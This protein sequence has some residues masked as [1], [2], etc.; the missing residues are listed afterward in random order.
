M[1]TA[2]VH[3]VQWRQDIDN[4]KNRYGELGFISSNFHEFHCGRFDQEEGQEGLLENTKICKCGQTLIEHR[5]DK[6]GDQ[7]RRNSVYFGRRWRSRLSS[8]RYV[9]VATSNDPGKILEYFS[10]YWKIK[11][12]GLVISVVGD[13]IPIRLGRNFQSKLVQFS[14]DA[15]AMI[16]T[17]GLDEGITKSV[18]KVF[19]KTNQSYK[20]RKIPL[21][22]LTPW[23]LIK[24]K[25]NLVADPRTFTSS[26]RT[27][28]KSCPD[29]ET[30]GNTRLCHGLGYHM[31]VDF[32]HDQPKYY[33]DT[34]V[35]EYSEI[36][37]QYRHR[38]E[39]KLME[40]N[41]DEHSEE[42]TQLSSPVVIVLAGGDESMLTYIDLAL[43][44]KLPVL[45]I[46]G[47]DGL[48]GF[49]AN[50]NSPN[51]EFD[52][53]KEAF[54]QYIAVKRS[55]TKSERDRI[56]SQLM[57]LSEN[58]QTD[59]EDC[60]AVCD[61]EKDIDFNNKILTVLLKSSTKH[62]KRLSRIMSLAVEWN[63]LKNEQ[64]QELLTLHLDSCDTDLFH[65][66]LLTAITTQEDR[67]DWIEE[68]IGKE[69]TVV[70]FN[71]FISKNLHQLYER[72][73]YDYGMTIWED[74][75]PTYLRHDEKQRDEVKTISERTFTVRVLKTLFD[76]YDD[77]F[78]ASEIELQQKTA[79]YMDRNIKTL[80]PDRPGNYSY[81]YKHLLIWAVIFL[82]S[83][84]AKFAWR[85][86][87]QEPLQS[88][89][90][91]C[92]LMETIKSQIDDRF[93]D[94]KR[95]LDRNKKMF[96][97]LAIQLLSA[98][99]VGN[100]NLTQL[101]L[102]SPSSMWGGL[103]V[104]QMAA[105]GNVTNFMAAQAVQKFMDD[106]WNGGVFVNVKRMVLLQVLPILVATPVMKVRVPYILQKTEGLEETYGRKGGSRFF[107]RTYQK[108]K[109]YFQS[110]RTKFFYHNMTYFVFLALF[111]YMVLVDFKKAS[112]TTIESVCL[113]W[114]L[115]L[116]VD[117]LYTLGIFPTAGW[118]ATFRD[119]MGVTT[120]VEFLNAML[121][122][123]G[124]CVHYVEPDQTFTKIAYSINLVIF[125]LKIFKAYIVDQTLG[126]QVVMVKEMTASMLQFLL[127]LLIFIVAYGTSSQALLYTER[128]PTFEIVR[129]IFYQPYWIVY[130]EVGLEE[131][132]DDPDCTD[133]A[134]FCRK[135]H[136]LVYIFLG[137]YILLSNV[138][139]LNLLIAIFSNI[140]NVIFEKTAA[141][142]RYNMYFLTYEYQLKT[143][144]VPPF[145][146]FIHIA[147]FLR[148]I[149][150]CKCRKTTERNQLILTDNEYDR[151]SR[152]QI[153]ERKNMFQKE[154][155]ESQTSLSIQIQ[156]IVSR[157]DKIE[158]SLSTDHKDMA[159]TVRLDRHNS[160]RS[161]RGSSRAVL[162]TK[163]KTDS[164]EN[165]EN[166]NEDSQSE[167][168]E[169]HEFHQTA[170]D[171][172]LAV[173]RKQKRMARKSTRE[174]VGEQ[175]EDHDE[176]T[177]NDVIK[178]K[179]VMWPNKAEEKENRESISIS[180]PD[181]DDKHEEE[182]DKIREE[183]VNLK[184]NNKVEPEN[185][186]VN[187]IGENI[188]K[189]GRQSN[190]L[191]SS[192]VGEILGTFEYKE[193]RSQKKKK[194]KTVQKE[195][196]ADIK[197]QE[198]SNKQNRKSKK[199]S[200]CREG[201]S[202]VEIANMT[203]NVEQDFE[204]KVTHTH[205]P[206]LRK[207]NIRRTTVRRSRRGNE[208]GNLTTL[209]TKD[210]DNTSMSSNKGISPY[211][212]SSDN[213]SQA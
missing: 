12:T 181:K 87:R 89:I 14:R 81:P 60:V 169:N 144:F 175:T 173:Q 176:E 177:I 165:I 146:I 197:G 213:E 64:V 192:L 104:L 174:R 154:L 126:P 122:V 130:G 131:I 210:K 55:Y 7:S 53:L 190:T 20:Q 191:L 93:Q 51:M 21:I 200:E 102:C 94:E 56:S 151:V 88:A 90:A 25:P 73:C 143:V 71:N 99:N 111:V 182:T 54:L 137:I 85:M 48:A 206:D 100:E 189:K 26:S 183:S 61:L 179:H 133:D 170:V 16:M 76:R 77:D 72:A 141:I 193:P 127:I 37:M 161:L 125:Q 70:D 52:D 65:E 147:H 41:E 5:K 67:L 13:E 10:K 118:K 149:L 30:R 22:G 196:D 103:S 207:E 119:I 202:N 114:I 134:R 185:S 142:W 50:A 28:T 160:K 92:H 156:K 34:R 42:H 155:K 47:T 32:P 29:I 33:S 44:A 129:D 168:D 86:L 27:H 117:E 153:E 195:G 123:L 212:S 158:E 1:N 107:V 38:I 45:V 145:S 112:V 178:N 136:G 209:H 110:P 159:G 15:D 106:I 43:K 82:R 91:M 180:K 201:E 121:F 69:S 6:R 203:F 152:M 205:Q 31:F 74:I 184:K 172:L 194:K 208:S 140:Y 188:R 75:A 4:T 59:G 98:C 124:Y 187:H 18:N 150:C 138:L 79:V 17:S 157:L 97:D 116:Q 198:N 132:G 96:E 163:M 24:H 39:Q 128:H 211:L 199:K 166:A 9:Q 3:D 115:T 186:N 120:I 40:L 46:K 108:F 63:M 204:S 36:V 164:V 68:L 35:G 105:S 135:Q 57:E 62:K 80:L 11:E 23:N 171:D 139:L 101:L 2:T 8:L 113:A 162:F 148:F 109:L 19:S 49:I 84:I 95:T 78:V 167:K 58:L 66:T 83:D